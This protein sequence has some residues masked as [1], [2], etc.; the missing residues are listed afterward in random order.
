MPL[1]SLA[2]LSAL[3]LSPPEMV[4]VAA[5]T[6]YQYV[7]LRLTPV[8]PNEP[9][10]PLAQDPDMLRET[11]QALAETG[12]GVLDI[13]LA[14]L[15]P[16]VDIASFSAMLEAGAALGARHVITQT[17]DTERTRAVEHFASFC[18]LA[19]QFSLTADLEFV[20]WTATPDLETA[21]AIVSAANQSNGGILIDTL[22]FR[23]SQ[24][25]T[26]LL[27][28]LPAKWFHFAQ[29]CDAPA[30]APAT[31]EGL[32]HAARNE[33]R[34]LGEGGL[35]VGCILECLP[36]DIPYSLEIPMTTLGRTLGPEVRAHMA[37]LSARRYLE[38][39]KRAA[40]APG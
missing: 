38:R 32:I 3:S 39:A 8:T 17:P 27:D 28:R 2:H 6:G 11:H 21:A 23:R 35:D 24:C 30:E 10:Y 26:G 18:E 15:T 16:E 40:H 37:I 31:T 14:R 1:F 36:A 22:H 33:R 12:I 9:R 13:E 7:G 25:Q 19:R 29:L 4:E 20:T 5:R 34:F